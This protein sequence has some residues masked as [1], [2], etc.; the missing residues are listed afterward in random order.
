[1]RL[2]CEF[3]THYF[4]QLLIRSENG[5]IGHHIAHSILNKIDSI[6][7]TSEY[8]QLNGNLKSHFLKSR[9]FEESDAYDS[10]KSVHDNT[11]ILNNPKR[12]EIY[13][14]WRKRYAHNIT[15]RNRLWDLYLHVSLVYRDIRDRL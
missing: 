14:T 13:K 4:S 1:M 5:A 9:Y 15:G 11:M 12:A 3:C 8:N 7:F 2:F 6:I 10:S